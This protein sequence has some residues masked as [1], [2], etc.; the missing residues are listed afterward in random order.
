MKKLLWISL[1]FVMSAS[2]NLFAGEYYVDVVVGEVD[3]DMNS[4]GNW[5]PA[6][7]GDVL[8]EGSSLRTGDDAFCDVIMPEQGLF[9][10]EENTEITLNEISGGASV[11]VKKG[12]FFANIVDLFSVADSDDTF[13]VETTSA[14]AAVRGTQ[15]SVIVSDGETTVSVEEGEIAA[16]P[17]I[18]EDIIALAKFVSQLESG[19]SVS[20]TEGQ[21]FT[22]SDGECSAFESEISGS[23]DDFLAE[24]EESWG[25]F[26]DSADDSWDSMFGDVFGDVSAEPSEEEYLAMKEEASEMAI[27]EVLPDVEESVESLDRSERRRLSEAF[28]DLSDETVKKRIGK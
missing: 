26:M 5:V 24:M 3:V 25:D 4:S 11:E 27:A 14:V 6:K 12:S 22:C 23:F 19:L 10:I 18:D 8:S 7:S 15:F 1:I 2:A 17:N 9:R 13:E 21:S 20:V 16:R 28:S